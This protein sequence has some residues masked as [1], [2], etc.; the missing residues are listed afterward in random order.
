[1]KVTPVLLN[2]TIDNVVLCRD[3][4]IISNLISFK[5]YPDNNVYLNNDEI[6]ICDYKYSYD[7]IAME[8]Q[9]PYYISN[10]EKLFNGI[11]S[12]Y[13]YDENSIPI[14]LQR[15]IDIAKQKA[16]EG[17]NEAREIRTAATNDEKFER[18]INATRILGESLFDA[19]IAL[20]GL[21]LNQYPEIVPG[22]LEDIILIT[23]RA[24]QYLTE[25]ERNVPSLLEQLNPDVIRETVLKIYN[26]GTSEIDSAAEYITEASNYVTNYP[27]VPQEAI[28]FI[29]IT[30]NF[31]LNIKN[32]VNTILAN[33][34]N[35]SFTNINN[36]FFE[37]TL[38]IGSLVNAINTLNEMA[39]NSE[40]QKYLDS[41]NDLL[42]ALIDY[43]FATRN[44]N[45]AQERTDPSEQAQILNNLSAYLESTGEYIIA[46]LDFEN[47]VTRNYLYNNWVSSFLCFCNNS[48][49]ENSDSASVKLLFRETLNNIK[50]ANLS[51]EICGTIGNKEFKAV[52]DTQRIIDFRELGLKSINI[53][54]IIS[55]I[56]N[57]KITL[58]QSI[59]PY[60]CIDSIN[61]IRNYDISTPDTIVAE[62]TG[63]LSLNIELLSAVKDALAIYTKNQLEQ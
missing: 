8:S 55:A 16:N 2:R 9:I 4:T 44:I 45:T 56:K 47:V 59:E 61:P 46:A 24:I 54:T 50:I 49:F 14:E 5:I 62:L 28:D 33:L 10:E 51:I 26:N 15:E 42:E 43:E 48:G 31:L 21:F 41:M 19:A 40:I 12:G 3:D 23:M 17:I 60:Y 52:S 29:D 25:A 13:Y 37:T 32:N 35:Q 20:E 7:Y 6:T 36:V 18:A 39:P 34:N 58:F 63:R 53:R 27:N 57:K 22:S 1:M 30:N 38:S 11:L